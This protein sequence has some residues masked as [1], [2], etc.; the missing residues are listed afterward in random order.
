MGGGSLSNMEMGEKIVIAGLFVQI[1]GAYP[2]SNFK[3]SIEC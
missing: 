3:Y 1:A 2:S